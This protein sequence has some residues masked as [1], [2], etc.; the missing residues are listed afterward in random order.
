MTNEDIKKIVLETGLITEEKLKEVEE[1]AKD[2]GESFE[3]EVVNQGLMS[4]ENLGQLIADSKGYHYVNLKNTEI[5]DEALAVIPEVV[6]KNQ[7]AIAYS[8]AGD[9]LKVAMHDPGNLDFIHLL[10]KKGSKFIEPYFATLRDLKQALNKYRKNITE[11]FDDIMKVNVEEAKKSAKAEDLPVIKI[12]DTLLAYAYQNGASDIHLEPYEKKSLVRYRID[13]VLHDVVD[14]PKKV[15]D[16]LITR[17][18]ILAKLRIDEHRAAQDGKLQFMTEDGRVDVRVSIVP[19]TEGEKVVMRL[20]SAKNRQYRLE[21]LGFSDKDLKIVSKA[22]KKPHGMILATGPTGSGKT[23][24]LYAILYVVNSREVNI[25]TVED[26]VEYDMEG[27]NQIQVNRT[28][29]LTFAN[30]LRSLLRQDPDIIMVGEI[31]DEET[32]NIAI[33]AA[34]TGHLV[35]STLH[36][37]DAATTIPRF[38]DMGAEPFLVSSTINVV[39]AQ[40]LVRKNCVKC[41]ASYTITYEELVKSLTAPMIAQTLGKKKSYRFYQSKGC[42]VCHHSGYR[43]R[44]GIYEVLEVTPAIK[45]MI[46][47]RANADE[48]KVQAIKEGMTTILE[49]GIQKVASGQTTIEEILRVSKE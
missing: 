40:R 4:D 29:D 45:E 2:N 31:R 27:V 44:M 11:E 48:I 22:I 9:T 30:G 15:H 42:A 34:M 39:I 19:I 37:N 3:E 6:A 43:G 26:P 16:L 10:E 12:A 21:S 28:T 25:S 20:L 47:Q 1:L 38:M 49:D 7:M 24:T 36:T 33:N 17:F 8:I 13:G 41:M 46:M 23:T 18:K 14:L 5:E 35:L 32:A